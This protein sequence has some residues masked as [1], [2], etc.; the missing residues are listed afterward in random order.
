MLQKAQSEAAYC[1]ERAD[2]NRRMAEQQTRPKLRQTYLDLAERWLKLAIGCEFSDRFNQY[3]AHLACALDAPKNED[4]AAQLPAQAPQLAASFMKGSAYRPDL[5][6]PM[7]FASVL[8]SLRT[9]GWVSSPTADME[10]RHSI[11]VDIRGDDRVG[12]GRIGPQFSRGVRESRRAD[13]AEGVVGRAAGGVGVD[14]RKIDLVR[15]R[16]EVGNIVAG[17]AG[18]AAVG[19]AQI[20]ERIDVRAAGEASHV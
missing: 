4:K 15:A 1:Q 20:T 13:E 16:H 11:A 8:N 14:R 7:S 18:D 5:N 19:R 3:S 12:A 17:R 2:E 10:V 6:R 9:R